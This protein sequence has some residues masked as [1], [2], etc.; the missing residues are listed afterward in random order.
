MVRFTPNDPI[1]TPSGNGQVTIT[2]GLP[3][4]TVNPYAACLNTHKLRDAGAV[5]V[6]TNSGAILKILCGAIL[7]INPH[8]TA[9]LT[10]INPPVLLGRPRVCVC[11]TTL[12][13]FAV[14]LRS[15]ALPTSYKIRAVCGH[16]HLYFLSTICA[17]C[18]HGIAE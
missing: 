5:R 2:P 6:S 1:C 13:Q 14:S 8:N 4:C 17:T 9:V 3:A 7:K 10:C 15:E 11:V 18:C 16:H 12:M